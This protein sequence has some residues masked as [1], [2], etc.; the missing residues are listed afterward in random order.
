M[1][2]NASL[3]AVVRGRNGPMGTKERQRERQELNQSVVT[4][5]FCQNVH[6]PYPVWQGRP[7]KVAAKLSLKW[8]GHSSIW[9]HINLMGLMS[10][11]T[12]STLLLDFLS[13]VKLQSSYVSY[14]NKAFSK[15]E[16]AL[17]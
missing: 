10:A 9:Q 6:S 14:K 5:T 7:N 16:I 13:A 17:V 15:E 12:A 8:P 4:T 3:T 1:E 11:V 2:K